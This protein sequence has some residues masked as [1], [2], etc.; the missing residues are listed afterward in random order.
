[1]VAQHKLP[2]C[3]DTPKWFDGTNG[4]QVFGQPSNK[5]WCSKYGHAAGRGAEAAGRAQDHCCV[6][7]GGRFLSYEVG[8][9][10][11]VQ[12]P[13]GSWHE[14]IIRQVR[15]IDGQLYFVELIKENLVGP[16]PTIGIGN[17]LSMR[18]PTLYAKMEMKRC[19]SDIVGQAWTMELHEN[20]TDD[21]GNHLVYLQHAPTGSYLG[22][23]VPDDHRLNAA[24]DDFPMLLNVTPGSSMFPNLWLILDNRSFTLVGGQ[25]AQPPFKHPQWRHQNDGLAQ[26]TPYQRWSLRC[27]DANV[28]EEDSGAVTQ[29]HIK[30]LRRQVAVEG[31]LEALDRLSPWIL[32]G[33]ERDA[34]PDEVKAQFRALSRRLHPDKQRGK[35]E[36]EESEKLFPLLQ[37]A[38]GGLKDG[39]NAERF[40]KDAETEEFLFARSR[41]VVE[42]TP[43]TLRANVTHQT[44]GED[45]KLWIIILYSPRCSMSRTI[46]PYLEIAAEALQMTEVRVGAYGCSMHGDGL[47]KAKKT[48]HMAVFSDPSCKYFGMSETPEIYG[49]GVGVIMH[50]GSVFME[51]L[52]ERLVEFGKKMQKTAVSAHL[53][54]T[55]KPETFQSEEFTEE[56]WL[57]AFVAPMAGIED[58]DANQGINQKAAKIT[59][60]GAEKKLM[61]AMRAHAPEVVRRLSAAG[62]KLGIA[63]C[64]EPDDSSQIN[65]NLID[66]DAEGLDHMPDI[67]IYGR[68]R[69]SGHGLSLLGERFSEPKDVEVAYEVATH[70][71][72]AESNITKV[73]LDELMELEPKEKEKEPEQPEG[74]GGGSCGAPPPEGA[75]KDAPKLPE[76][77]KKTDKDKVEGPD[78]PKDKGKDKTSRLSDRKRE[79]KPKLSSRFSQRKSG[80]KARGVTYGGG[81]GGGGGLLAR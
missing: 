9:S 39:A 20:K 2:V 22:A 60:T 63:E 76:G 18:R 6:C 74:G 46:V 41:H 32:L 79:Q 69:G 23:R 12:D 51:R 1:V 8:E 30:W 4:C 33:V 59:T 62:V 54:R 35:Q 52:P 56:R 24:I 64:A 55:V 5:D 75:P 15:P 3:Y 50:F 77:S 48:G 71:L 42:L 68:G 28:T 66:C 36:R 57:I 47:D 17:E 81:G 38:Y 45:A 58:D 7:G 11:Q 49:V 16:P 40:K 80:N 67:R 25:Y 37:H 19:G 43:D 78:A 53:V 21:L 73:D 27:A 65:S 72:L 34:K 31:G 44:A 29:E 70:V 10:V 61:T 14:A 26:H 13:H